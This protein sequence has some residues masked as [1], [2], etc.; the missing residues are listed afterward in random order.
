MT[1]ERMGYH[2]VDN[3]N[4]WKGGAVANDWKTNVITILDLGGEAIRKNLT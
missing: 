4:K 1:D 3:G 2:P